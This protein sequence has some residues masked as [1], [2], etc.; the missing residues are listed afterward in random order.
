MSAPPHRSP[1]LRRL[2]GPLVGCAVSGLIWHLHGG[3]VPRAIFAATLLLAALAL[4]A[5]RL[6]AP[7]QRL[8]EGF[9]R[10]VARAVTWVVLGLLFAGVFVPGRLLLRL[11]RKDPLQLRRS[12]VDSYWQSPRTTPGAESFDRQF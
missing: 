1:L 9:G 2:A 11:R 7:V 3:T 4:A 6:Y 5:P 12:A 8:L 10:G